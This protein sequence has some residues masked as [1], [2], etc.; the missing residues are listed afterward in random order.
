MLFRY[1]IQEFLSISS[2][3]QITF[4]I[5]SLDALLSSLYFYDVAGLDRLSPV[6][7]C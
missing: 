3:H 6:Q 4:F 1:S 7:G 2:S 5:D